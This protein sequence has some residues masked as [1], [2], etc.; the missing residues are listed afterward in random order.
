MVHGDQGRLHGEGNKRR[1]CWRNRM[2]EEGTE[3]HTKIYVGHRELGDA[4]MYG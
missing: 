4:E 3:E 1:M 2:L